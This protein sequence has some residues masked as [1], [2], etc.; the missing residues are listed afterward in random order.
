MKSSPIQFNS[1]LPNIKTHIFSEMSLLANQ[2]N[3]INLSQGFPNFEPSVVLQN[4][5]NTC[6][7]KGT[8]QYAPAAGLLSLRQKIAGKI[9][10][11]YAVNIDAE[12][13]VTIT[14]GATEAI[15]NTISAFVYPAD[16]V[17]L[18][19]PCYDCYRPAIELAGGIAVIYKMTAPGF[20]VDWAELKKLVSTKTRMICISS[21]NNPTGTVFQ[22]QDMLALLS[23][24]KDTNIIIMSDEVYEHMVYDGNSHESPLK[25]PGLRE[26]T[27]SCFSFGKTF[28]IT[29]W[30]IGYCIASPALTS[31]LRKIH[32][33][34]TFC[35]SHPLQ[36]AIAAFM[37][38]P[39]QYL[40]LPHFYQAKRDT[41]LEAIANSRFKALECDGTYFQLLDYSAISNEDDYSFCR[42]LI[43]E[44]GVAAIPI[45]HLYSDKHDDKIIRICFAK[46]DD[47]LRSAGL[48]LSKI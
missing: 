31:E 13:Q 12:T 4:L 15:F 18:I 39:G 21:P 14:A 20:K 37:E 23:V 5:V 19:E 16:E 44:Y 42:R 9:A 29:G 3:A 24:V 48:L 30:R 41:F 10:L 25:Y 38:D 26:R 32:Q 46:T 45:S 27:V 33:N 28:H 1:K 6:L 34:N 11:T 40:Y 35:A 36:S 47:V 17:I 43:T 7:K 2:Y 22:Q 8:N